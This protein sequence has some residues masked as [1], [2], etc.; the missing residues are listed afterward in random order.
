MAAA[1]SSSRARSDARHPVSEQNFYAD[2]GRSPAQVNGRLVLEKQQYRNAS[3]APARRVETTS[4]HFAADAP[5]QS[6]S[7]A[8]RVPVSVAD[9]W[10]DA[11]PR[12]GAGRSKTRENAAAG[13]SRSGPS[14]ASSP[15][16]QP[17]PTHG[18]AARARTNGAAGGQDQRPIEVEGEEGEDLD[19][20]IAA[21]DTHSGRTDD[22]A[23]YRNRFGARR[24]PLGMDDEVTA[25]L[26]A[27]SSP[28]R[29]PLAYDSPQQTRPHRNRYQQHHDQDV[30]P[31]ARE[32]DEA[33]PAS[34]ARPLKRQINISAASIDVAS[35]SRSRG[36]DRLGRVF[37]LSDEE[38]ER[39]EDLESMA[40]DVEMLSPDE[41]QWQMNGGRANGKAREIERDRRAERSEVEQGDR[42]R[43]K[44]A[45]MR[46]R[47]PDP[48]PTSGPKT[49]STRSRQDTVPPYMRTENHTHAWLA[50]LPAVRIY[51]PG[52]DCAQNEWSDKSI[53]A[54]MEVE[55][56]TLNISGNGDAHQPVT[57]VK[58]SD[59]RSCTVSLPT[60]HV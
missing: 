15:P 52:G 10:D 54:C 58:L 3:N 45:P 56:T 43:H 50:T 34:M 37:T 59:V 26:G 39:A 2:E 12:A 25:P 16:R 7:N 53:T 47:N 60:S 36:S 28:G 29:D 11:V 51:L 20:P 57:G 31:S 17:Y 14:H 22:K 30:Y 32:R 21:M 6:R 13:P 8:A 35:T 9:G 46:L 41:A 33:R 1:G 18:A 38:P 4:R 49:R 44:P 27:K 23:T 24:L 42:K 55:G 40:G 5:A 19:D 48:A